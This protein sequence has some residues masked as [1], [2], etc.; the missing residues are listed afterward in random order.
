MKTI[1]YFLLSVGV[2]LTTQIFAQ[3]K[4]E[5]VAEFPD[6]RPGNVAVSPEGRVFVTMS[7]LGESK[8]MVKEVLSNGTAV[9]FPDEEWIV[10]TSGKS[11]KGINATIGIHVSNDNILWVLD[12]GDEK[13]DTKKAPK[14]VSFNIKTKKLVKVFPFPDDVLQFNSFLQDFVIDEKNQIAVI[15]DMTYAGLLPPIKPAFIVVDL[16]TGYTRRVLENDPSFMPLDEAVVI[17]DRPVSHLF[18]NGGVLQPSYPL[19]PISIDPQREWIYFGAMGGKKIYRIK[20]EAVANEKLSD[21]E[22]SKQIQFYAVK[23]KSDG[24]KVGNNGK[25]YVTDVE[26]NAVGVSTPNGYTVLAQDKD[27]LSWPDGVSISKDGYLYIVANQLHNLPWLNNN[28]D[29]SKPPYYVVR[30]KID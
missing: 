6:A 1:K 24:F 23:P 4:I 22:L 20:S 14:L 7:A 16:K 30:I 28:I 25:V 9:P 10:K 8:F 27:L 13:G 29:T 3:K 2:L 11:M 26:N 12:M 19:N 18:P 15:A 5:I 21:N 17:N